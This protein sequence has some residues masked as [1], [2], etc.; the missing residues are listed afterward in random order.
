MKTGNTRS[1]PLVVIVALL[2]AFSSPR[3]P[4]RWFI[5]KATEADQGLAN[6][7]IQRRMRLCTEHSLQAFVVHPD[8]YIPEIAHFG[9]L[10][11]QRHKGRQRQ[12]QFPRHLANLDVRIASGFAD[13]FNPPPTWP[14]STPKQPTTP[15][16]RSPPS[17]PPPVRS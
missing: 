7:N 3:A 17:R 14:V 1:S 8:R 16:L 10:P 13:T 2:V 9:Q 6:G 12:H 4:L 15:T 5:R 11:K